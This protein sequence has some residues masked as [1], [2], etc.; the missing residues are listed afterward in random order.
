[1]G[2][3]KE[4]PR[5][6]MIGMMYLVLTALLALN[7][8]KDILNA[9][10]LVDEGLNKTVDN[11]NSKSAILY[12]ALNKAKMTNP[13]K[14][15]EWY[16]KSQVVKTSADELMKYIDDIKIQLVKVADG[17]N[18]A[19]DKIRTYDLQA[20]DNQD[21]GGQIMILE[22]GGSK[23]KEKINAY[24]EQ[25][26]K[27]TDPKTGAALRAQLETGLNTKDPEKP[28]AGGEHETWE[29]SN[30]EHLPLVAVTTLLTKMQTDIRNAE[31]DVVTYLAGQIGADDFRFNKIEAIVK[32]ESNY[33][34]QG[35][36]YKAEVFI[37]ASD[38]TVKPEILVGGSPLNVKNGKAE[39][40]VSG[41]A[42]GMKSWG[43]VIRL[44]TPSTNTVKEYPFKAEYQVA[45]PSVT[46]SPTKMNV[47]YIGVDNPVDIL[48][49]GIPADKIKASISSGSITSAGGDGKYIVRVKKTGPA[50]ISISAEVGGKVVSMGSRNFRV[51]TVPDPIAKVAGLAGGSIGINVL[52][53]QA[54]VAADLENFDFE[55][56]FEVKSF[57]VSATVKG[58]E[59]EASSNSYAFTAQQKQLIAKMRPQS[60]IYITDIKAQGPDGVPRSLPSIAFKLK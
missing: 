20:K 47:F 35:D 25:L 51:K 39:Y 7:V 6:K 30:F 34:L 50:V 13:A 4:T 24:R 1:M 31:A 56:K 38:T 22:K 46:V 27:L 42:I 48:A 19:P 60:K 15:T 14:A 36:Q 8:S 21:V 26:V 32:A 53:A 57:T 11:F 59:E 33:I 17:V 45:A 10:V 54:G 3:G 43:G 18:V 28:N 5:Q 23:L 2:H 41:S 55:L 12:T 40:V 52:Q 16:D 37:A 49:S 9:F 44:T 29:Q 58:Y